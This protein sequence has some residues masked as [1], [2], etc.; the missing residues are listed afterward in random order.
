MSKRLK[1]AFLSP[2]GPLYRH[3]GGIFRK[4]LR[5]SPLTFSTLASLI[6]EDIPADATVYDEGVQ[7][8]DPDQID[9]DLAG[10]TV[11]TGNAARCYEFAAKF[12]AR[13]VPVVMGGP[14]PTL[15]PDDA[16]PHA[17]AIVTG[18]AEETWPELLR[19]FLSGGMKPRYV[20]D[21]DFSFARM[22][23]I[24]FPRR[25][26]MARK[27]YR[28]LNTF[29]AT[30]GCLH[31]CEFCVVPHA[32]GKKPYLKPI[33]HVLADIRQMNARK[34]LFYDLN[35][36]AS[37]D[38]AAD[39][40]RALAPL[41]IKWYGLVTA[42]IGR[43]TELLEL[44]ARSGCKGLLVGFETVS[45]AAL[46]D[47]HKRFND[48]RLYID[49]VKDLQSLGIA[50]NGCFAFGSDSDTVEA[51]DE[52]RDF[53]LEQ[54]IELPRFAILTPFPGTRLHHRLA[55]DGRILHKDWSQY[56]GQ[57]VV[58]QPKN[59]TPEE[60]LA[61]HRRVWEEI[62][63]IKSILHRVR[64]KKVNY[65]MMLAANLAYRYYAHRLHKFYTCNAGMP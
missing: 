46:A 31:D 48:P 22:K 41:K 20:M 60:L 17:D 57:H 44:A 33:D 15:A 37:R 30:R 29:E 3:R 12:R 62:Y 49:F 4:A 19:D 6:P 1:I 50:I 51:F 54:R 64:G 45:K 23:H 14:H 39:L 40:F 8:V 2:K 11:I 10:I 16:Q 5:P 61:G 9:A 58:F 24:P 32:W 18:Y 13:G 7:D 56:D 65:F 59:M 52:V 42:L 43:D 53:V 28:T 36:I 25:E 63:S 27:G 38:H 26:I 55:A 21:P 34:L 47:M 35:I